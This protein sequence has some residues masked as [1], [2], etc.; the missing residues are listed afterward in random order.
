MAYTVD[1][2]LAILDREPPQTLFK[3]FDY[4]KLAMAVHPDRNPGNTKAHEVYLL[5]QAAHERSNLPPVVIA[6]GGGTRYTV[7]RRFAQGDVADL[8]H[9]STNIGDRVVLKISR[10][11]HGH[12]LM[13]TE[14]T[15]LQKMALADSD[16][17]SLVMPSLYETFLAKDKMQKRVTVFHLFPPT[18]SLDRVFIRHG[19]LRGKH[20]GWIMDAMLKACELYHGQGIVHG[21]ILPQHI[22][23]DVVNHDVYH[24]G[25][26]QSVKIGQPI[27]VI[28]ARY[29]DWYPP[30]VMAKQPAGPETD[31]YM[32]GKCLQFL[33]GNEEPKK[34]HK[35]MQQFL[36]S[37]TL[38]GRRMRPQS[39]TEV[40]EDSQELYRE[41]YG[42]Q[43]FDILAM[44]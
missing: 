17:Y 22:L 30:E 41:L 5:L 4:K 39:A 37:L 12:R 10:I 42:E 11:P 13:E 38:P 15:H 34:V 25:W 21:A 14:V 8:Y 32:I 31:L 24:V 23:L 2:V 40:R 16:R 28:S 35:R 33:C 43:P 7:I 9:A 29:R 36:S 27:K 26:A 6:G 3:T 18:W 19:A 20:I 1:Q 44:S